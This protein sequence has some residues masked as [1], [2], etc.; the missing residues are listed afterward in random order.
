MQI[1]LVVAV[2]GSCSHSRSSSG[3]SFSCSGFGPEP[4]DLK[5]GGPWVGCSLGGFKC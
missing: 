2:D 5:V 4:G 3:S 1:K